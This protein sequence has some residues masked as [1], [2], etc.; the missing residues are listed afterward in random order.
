MTAPV[1]TISAELRQILARLRLGQMADTLPERLLTARQSSLPHIDFLEMVLA[2]EV[3]RRDKT[4][5]GLRARTAHLDPAMVAEA[6]DDTAAVTYDHATWAEL[7]TLRFVDDHHNA[8]ILGPVGVGKTFLARHRARPYRLSAALPGPLRTGRQ[9]V[10]AAA[11]GPARQL[12]GGRDA[13]AGRRRPV[14]HR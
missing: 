8:L 14:A 5:A 12:G 4:S 7:T 3:A 10:Q 9:V 11:G 2:D 1:P 13:Q 6:W